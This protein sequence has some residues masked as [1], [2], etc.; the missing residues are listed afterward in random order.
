MP[1]IG[2]SDERLSELKAMIDDCFDGIGN[3]TLNFDSFYRKGDQ[4][5]PVAG[6]I[7]LSETPS[8]DTGATGQQLLEHTPGEVF[9][10]LFWKADERESIMCLEQL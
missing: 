5:R 10:L 9:V 2:V 3:F 1:A 8:T 4:L 7:P 6:L